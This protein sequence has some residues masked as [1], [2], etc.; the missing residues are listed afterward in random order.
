MGKISNNLQEI[1]KKKNLSIQKL[2]KLSGISEQNLQCY[3]EGTK[4]VTLEDFVCLVNV[5]QIAPS[6][7]LE[8]RKNPQGEIM[9]EEI[10]KKIT[11]LSE[12]ERQKLFLTIENFLSSHYN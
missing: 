5:L 3:E 8:S 10:M 4:E 11:L 9:S 12:E 7:L 2:A 1:R 6:E